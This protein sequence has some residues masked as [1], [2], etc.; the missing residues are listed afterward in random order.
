MTVQAMFWPSWPNTLV[1]PIFRP[2]IP[3]MVET[4][5]ACFIAPWAF[6]AAKRTAKIGTDPECTRPKIKK[7]EGFQGSPGGVPKAVN[8]YFDYQ[9][10]ERFS[11]PTISTPSPGLPEHDIIPS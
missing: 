9:G 1:I 8:L 2:K 10:F 4:Y 7:S 5:F 6:S 11:Y 3:G